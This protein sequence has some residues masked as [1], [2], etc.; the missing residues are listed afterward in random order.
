MM[1]QRCGSAKCNAFKK[2]VWIELEARRELRTIV[3]AG[4]WPYYMTGWLPERG[5]AGRSRLVDG[6]TKVSSREENATVLRRTLTKTIH[7]LES[8]GK[9][10]VVIGSV[11]EPGFN[12]PYA[13]A[14]A[15]HRRREMLPGIP[16]E[17]VERRAGKADAL[18]AMITKGRAHSRFI[19]IWQSFCGQRW[20]AIASDGVPLYSDDD[21]LSYQGALRAGARAT[22]H[23][24]PQR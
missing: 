14:M 12:V 5:E 20:C 21:H 22:S 3:L 23:Y 2:E 17:I 6:Q 4:R 7:R 8:M 19:S 18:V 16:R 10:V 1:S 11:P 15:L 24:G 9:N 13:I